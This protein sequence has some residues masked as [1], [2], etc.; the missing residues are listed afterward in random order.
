MY[1]PLMFLSEWLE[2]PSTTFLA[3][4]K[5]MTARVST[6]LKSRASPDMLPFRLRNKKNLAIRQMDGPL[7]PTTISIPA[8]DMWKQVGLR[9]YQQFLVL[10]LLL[11]LVVLVVVIEVVVII[12]IL[13]I[14]FLTYLTRQ[15]NSTMP[16]NYTSS[17]KHPKLTDSDKPTHLL[18][19][20]KFQ[21]M[22][23]HY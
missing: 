1:V 6:L 23:Q 21:R 19:S 8:Y 7:I 4:K 17:T 3:E 5:L 15:F 9:T 13:I 18:G 14:E 22:S 2:F 11:V 12:I 16:T 10:L 20:C